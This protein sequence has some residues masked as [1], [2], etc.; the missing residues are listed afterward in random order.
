MRRQFY[1]A[2]GHEFRRIRIHFKQIGYS[3]RTDLRP[4][5]GHLREIKWQDAGYDIMPEVRQRIGGLIDTGGDFRVER[6]VAEAFDIAAQFET[7]SPWF[8]RWS[9]FAENV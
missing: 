5:L 6:R 2:F 3:Y 8:N 9:E 1:K 7:V 4:G